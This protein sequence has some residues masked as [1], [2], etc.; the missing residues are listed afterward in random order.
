VA[1][2]RPHAVI[3]EASSGIG[4]AFAAHLA[5]DGYDLTLLACRRSRLAELAARLTQAVP[6]TVEV[7]AADLTDPLGACVRPKTGSRRFADWTC[8]STTPDGPFADLDAAVAAAPIGVH[9][10]APTRLTRA[11]ARTR[12]RGGDQL[13]RLLASA[14]RQLDDRGPGWET[15]DLY[16][17]INRL[18]GAKMFLLAA[19]AL[20]LGAV[21]LRTVNLPRW[22]ASLGV[23]LVLLAAGTPNPR[24]AEQ[25]VVSLDTVKKHVSHLP[26]KLGAANRTEAVT[27]ARQLGLIP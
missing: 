23:L 4:A 11:P 10:T 19:I 13:G 3:T 15:T 20:A 21:T 2:D 6:V 27:R 24:I 17:A 7:H 9:V 8:W 12:P 16:H 25:L 5:S 14:Q 18:D 22:L 1:A 26:G